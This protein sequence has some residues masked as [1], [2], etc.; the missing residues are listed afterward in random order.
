MTVTNNYNFSQTYSGAVLQ[1]CFQWS[2]KLIGNKH[3]SQNNRSATVWQDSNRK[4]TICLK[5]IS[6]CLTRLQPYKTICLKQ[7]SY[8]L[9]R[10]TPYKTMCL[11]QISYCLTR[12]TPYKT[13]CLKQIRYCLTRF[14]P[15]KPMCLKQIS[16]CLT[17][18]QPYTKC[19]RQSDW[20]RSAT[21]WQ[22]S[23]LIRQCV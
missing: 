14:Q 6:Y 18:F 23:N 9:T 21:V 5:Q 11:K 1:N 7:I 10:F 13:M 3:A 19:I 8:C 17:R 12:F 4:R 16:Y 20:N 22:D 15:Y 2:W